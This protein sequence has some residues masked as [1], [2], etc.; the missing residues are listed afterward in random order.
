[1][2]IYKGTEVFDIGKGYG[3]Y[4]YD[5]FVIDNENDFTS[6]VNHYGF[7]FKRF[8]YYLDDFNVIKNNTDLSSIVKTKMKNFDANISITFFNEEYMNNNI[9]IKQVIINELNH[10]GT[11]DMFSFY[12]YYFEEK[13]ASDYLE[14][15]MAYANSKLHNAAINYFT[16]GIMLDPNISQIYFHRGISH[17][18]KMNIEQAIC[19]LTKAIEIDPLEATFYSYRG[20]LYKDK[21]ESDKAVFDLSKAIE[22]DSSNS[23]FYS[24]RGAIYIDLKNI[25]KARKDIKR[26]LELNPKDKLAK[27]CFIELNKQ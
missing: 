18:V 4:E 7:I 15:G 6:L 3:E 2:F 9:G 5:F 20:Y 26:A 11:Y 27:K 24:M 16:Q 10:D 13:K 1:M 17:H 22:L 14:R 21:N 23:A 12:Y 19:D 8:G 25:E